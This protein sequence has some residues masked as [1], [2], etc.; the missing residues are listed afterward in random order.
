M[1]F[2]TK[3]YKINPEVVTVVTVMIKNKFPTLQA[4]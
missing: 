2:K 4:I 1:S 3:A